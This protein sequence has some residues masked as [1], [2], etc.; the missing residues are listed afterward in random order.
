MH[1][2]GADAPSRESMSS[3]RMEHGFANDESMRQ[4]TCRSWLA[5]LPFVFAALAV[6]Q[7]VEAQSD[8]EYPLP[9]PSESASPAP[10]RAPSEAPLHPVEMGPENSS[11]P[12]H[13]PAVGGS[14]R[15]GQE[16]PFD[17]TGGLRPFLESLP[18]KQRKAIERR[19]DRKA[20][21][22]LV[23]RTD[24]LSGMYVLIHEKPPPPRVPLV[25]AF[26][27]SNGKVQILFTSGIPFRIPSNLRIAR[28]DRMSLLL[29]YIFFQ[30][31]SRVPPVLSQEAQPPGP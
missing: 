28:E 30:Q 3:S 1:G 15:T 18:E 25:H 2:D 13:S 19:L 21:H 26:M 4:R 6:P 31:G 20:T 9:S 24:S 29:S 17:P 7:S 10:E 23:G 11:Q 22:A 14:S 12:G 27:L 16:A 5:A 8:P